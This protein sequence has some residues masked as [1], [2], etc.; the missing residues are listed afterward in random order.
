MP[1]TIT[2]AQKSSF[3]QDLVLKHLSKMDKGRLYLSLPGGEQITIGPV[4]EI[5][6]RVFR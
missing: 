2:V 4:K 3:Y 5:L 6:Q 1:N